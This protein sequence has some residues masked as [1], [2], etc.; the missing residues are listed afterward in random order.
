LED[1]LT[2]GRRGGRCS[3]GP[4][5]QDRVEGGAA[6]AKAVAEVDDGEAGAAVGVSPLFGEGVGLGA[7]DAEQGGRFFDGEELGQS[8]SH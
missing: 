4:A 5:A 3:G 7:A 1:G 8:I 6:D 2:H